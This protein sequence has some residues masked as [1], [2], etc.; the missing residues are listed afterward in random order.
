MMSLAWLGPLA[1]GVSFERG[2]S[3]A[4]ILILAAWTLIPAVIATVAPALRGSP[5]RPSPATNLQGISRSSL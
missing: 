2:G 1:V 3:T 5:P 4:T